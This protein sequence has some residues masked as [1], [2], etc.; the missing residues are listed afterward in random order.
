MIPPHI[1]GQTEGLT[2]G[3]TDRDKTVYPPPV[4]RGYNQNIG[5]QLSLFQ[6][7]FIVKKLPLNNVFLYYNILLPTFENA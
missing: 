6:N 5:V 1:L 7:E 3:R 2:D 4:D